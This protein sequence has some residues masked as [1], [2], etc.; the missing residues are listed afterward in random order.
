MLFGK[1]ESASAVESSLFEEISTRAAASTTCRFTIC[2][3]TTCMVIPNTRMSGVKVIPNTRIVRCQGDPEYSWNT[4][5]NYPL[6]GYLSLDS[7]V[8]W[9]CPFT[10][11]GPLADRHRAHGGAVVSA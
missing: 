8:G 3:L 10:H 6:C 5:S 1:A 11:C 7:A 2:V 4:L 9:V